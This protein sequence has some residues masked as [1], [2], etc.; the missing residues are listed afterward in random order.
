MYNQDVN[1]LLLNEMSNHPGSQ[2]TYVNSPAHTLSLETS[3]IDSHIIQQV[4]GN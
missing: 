4:Q 3:Y 1:V 2:K